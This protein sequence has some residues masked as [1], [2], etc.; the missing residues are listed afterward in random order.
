MNTKLV[1]Y[2]AGIAVIGFVAGVLFNAATVGLFAVA[3]IS[4]V[5]L[6]ALTDYAPAHDYRATLA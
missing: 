2:I 1:T 4:L 6:I 3:V 5:T